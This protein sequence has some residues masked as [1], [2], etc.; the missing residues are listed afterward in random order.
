M[1]FQTWIAF[2]VAAG[3]VLVIPGPTIIAVI[4]HSLAHGRR[5]VVPL[6]VGVTVGDFTAMTLSLAGLGAVM[7]ASATLFSIL[8]ILGALYL[9]YLGVKLWRANPDIEAPSRE[10]QTASG[11]SL[12]T[13]LFVITALNP[14]SIAFFIAFLPQF[15][16]PS[17][18]ALPQL[19]LLGGTFLVLAALNAT[20]YALFAGHLREKVRSSK[21]RRWFNRCGGTA[22][23]GASLVTAAMRRS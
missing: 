9:M 21:T 12:L 10:V 2:A 17:A 11:R 1:T 6:V 16:V 3:I 14:K 15:V 8:K 4:S 7:A 19:L 18:E 20:L 23:I 5:A 13:N 22:L